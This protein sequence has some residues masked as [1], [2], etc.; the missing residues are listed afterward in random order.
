[1]I[2]EG[3]Q[4]FMNCGVLAA[5][6]RHS[7]YNA[8]RTEDKDQEWV[9]ETDAENKILATHVKGGG[10]GYVTYGVSRWTAEDGRT[11]KR[12][13]EYEFEE[14]K[15][16]TLFWDEI[17][18]LLYPEQFQLY[19]R[20]TDDKSRVELDSVEEIAVWDPSYGSFVRK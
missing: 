16:Y 11:L 13:L 2:I 4:Y 1:M 12:L 19:V 9:V 3:D 15:N 8:F 18:L 10:P 7:E 14:K 5:E 20:P 17:P 6:F